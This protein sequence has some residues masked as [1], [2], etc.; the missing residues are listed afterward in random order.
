MSS[1]ALYRLPLQQQAVL[2]EQTEGEPLELMACQELNGH[3]GFVVSPFVA[4]AN[5]PILL[6]RPDHKTIMSIEDIGEATITIPEN[7]EASGSQAIISHH[8]STDNYRH[9]FALFHSHLVKGDFQKIVLSRCEE[10]PRDNSLKPLQLFCNA[11]R[12]YPR[13]FIALV[14]T[15]KSGLWLTATPEV[16]LES[17]GPKWRTIALAGTMRANGQEEVQWSTKNRNEQQIVAKYIKN[18]LK[19]L[20]TDIDEEGPRTVSAANLLHLRTDFTFNLGKSNKVGDLLQALHPTPAVCGLPKQEALQ[21]I[22]ANE[23]TPRLYYSGF[24]GPLSLDHT[25]HL[26]VSLRCMQITANHYRLYAGGGLLPESNEDQEWM[27]TE[28]KLDTMRQCLCQ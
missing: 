12:R 16:L 20:A 4:N 17:D 2:I 14:Y 24:M 8:L 25:T 10:L 28:A 15:P 1:F 23:H 5:L 19:Q 27:E 7:Q 22:V 9:D 26:F 13:L 18:C 21:F 11:C 3:Q 6:I